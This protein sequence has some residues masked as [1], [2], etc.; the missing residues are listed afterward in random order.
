MIN[1][2]EFSTIN[3]K[4]SAMKSKMLTEQDFINI[5]NLGSVAEVFNYLN[6]NTDMRDVLWDLNGK[7]IHRNEVERALYRYRIL[8]MEKI[9]LYLGDE[10]KIFLKKY[11]L[12]YE[13]EDLKLIFEVVRGSYTPENI[14]DH[15]FSSFRYSEINFAELIEQSTVLQVL[16]KLKGTK[17]YRLI[18]PYCEHVDEKFSFYIEMILDKYYYHQL[19]AAAKKLPK[20]ENNKSTELLRRNIDLL[21]LEWI[22]RATKYFDMSKEEILNFVLDYGYS[23]DYEKLKDLIYSYDLNKLLIHLADSQYA[24]LFNH[25]NDIDMYMERRIDR[26]TYYKSL[27]LYRTSILNFGKVLAYV[28]LIE[29]EVKDVI[30]VIESKRYNLNAK[31]ISKYL[32][33]TIEVVD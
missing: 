13:I 14:E 18:Q 27:S 21:N 7:K 6:D 22:Y 9:M 25:E 23:Y 5:M 12:R 24:F 30:S 29:F 4:I 28:Q 1:K 8:V 26:Y 20:E 16:D 19:I 15:L 31:E 3:T 2:M 32:I 11:M 17:Y 10:Y 33:R